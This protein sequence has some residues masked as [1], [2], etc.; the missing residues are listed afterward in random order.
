MR[1]LDEFR[2]QLNEGGVV[3]ADEVSMLSVV[4]AAP[5]HSFRETLRRATDSRRHNEAGTAAVLMKCMK[6]GWGLNIRLLAISDDWQEVG[7]GFRV[8][9]WSVPVNGA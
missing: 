7:A 6:D 5:K 3:G 2:R 9:E 8:E 1:Y 4:I